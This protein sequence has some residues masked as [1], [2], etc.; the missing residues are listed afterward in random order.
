MSLIYI[1]YYYFIPARK[2]LS[3]YYSIDYY[4][5]IN[6]NLRSLIHINLSLQGKLLNIGMITPLD[7]LNLHK[8]LLIYPCKEN[9]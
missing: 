2:M 4:L 3:F 8:L 7:V 5:L 9:A 1:N 6:L